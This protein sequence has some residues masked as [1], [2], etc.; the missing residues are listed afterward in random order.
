MAKGFDCFRKTDAHFL[1]CRK[2][3]GILFLCSFLP[4]QTIQFPLNIES[5]IM[6]CDK[7]ELHRKSFKE[8]RNN[9]YFPKITDSYIDSSVA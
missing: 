6:N 8:L 2:L 7:N 3:Y 5:E 9:E 4:P 1:S